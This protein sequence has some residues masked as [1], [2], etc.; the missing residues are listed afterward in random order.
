MGDE[1]QNKAELYSQKPLSSRYG[2][3]R[4]TIFTS[5]DLF[6]SMCDWF[7]TSLHSTMS[8]WFF[9]PFRRG[10]WCNRRG[11]CRFKKVPSFFPLFLPFQRSWGVSGRVGK[12][13]MDWKWEG[14]KEMRE[15]AFMIFQDFLASAAVHE[16]TTVSFWHFR[17]LGLCMVCRAHSGWCEHGWQ[18]QLGK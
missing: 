1:V 13:T 9:S 3:W 7:F 11:S 17:S 16:Q 4:V 14:K 2:G 6:F 12:K 8:I 15:L 5:Y 18:R 10:S